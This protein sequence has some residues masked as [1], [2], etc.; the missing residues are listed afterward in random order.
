MLCV[1]FGEIGSISI[2]II[3]IIDVAFYVTFGII[4]FLSLPRNFLGFSINI[5]ILNNQY[6]RAI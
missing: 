1:D 4:K 5:A 6:L 2:K 3:T